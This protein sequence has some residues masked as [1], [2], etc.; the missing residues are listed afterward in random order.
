MHADSTLL[1]NLH[2]ELGVD[3]NDLDVEA[4]SKQVRHFS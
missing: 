1:L 4:D 2:F 3:P